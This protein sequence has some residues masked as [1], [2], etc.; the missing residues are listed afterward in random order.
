[1]LGTNIGSVGWPRC[2]ELDIMEALGNAPQTL[3]GTAHMADNNGNRTLRGGTTQLPTPL[4]D[5]Y[6][7]FAAK[8]TPTSI[9]WMVDYKPYFT[10]TKADFGYA[11]WPFGPS[12]T[13]AAPRMYAI[14]NI[15]MGGD[16]GGSIAPGLSSATMA[17]DWVRYYQIDGQG[18]VYK[19]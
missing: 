6:H 9:T 14:L 2:G 1:M 13:G 12:A 8:W 10:V 11:T 3:W 18:A 7:V 15:A 19:Y 4:S 17:V 16:M 5:G